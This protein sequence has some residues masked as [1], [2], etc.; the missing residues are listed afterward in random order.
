MN[1]LTNISVL[2][3]KLWLLLCL[4]WEAVRRFLVL[5]LW[6]TIHQVVLLHRPPPTVFEM[7]ASITKFL[8]ISKA[9]FALPLSAIGIGKSYFSI[10]HT[11]RPRMSGPVNNI[12]DEASE[13][14]RFSQQYLRR[15]VREIHT[16]RSH[17]EVL[18][19]GN[20]YFCSNFPHASYN[21]LKQLKTNFSNRSL[22]ERIQDRM[23]SQSGP[24]WPAFKPPLCQ[25][26]HHLPLLLWSLALSK[27][28]GI[29]PNTMHP[30]AAVRLQGIYPDDD[31]WLALVLCC[32]GSM[33]TR[34]NC[35]LAW[36]DHLW[37]LSLR[38]PGRAL[39]SCR[40]R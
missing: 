27:I 20:V 8:E 1:P 18:G 12:S 19:T 29:L 23:A 34:R 21:K 36:L 10:F 24:K 16:H 22:L 14:V 25:L 5:L 2:A 3:T 32:G 9:T 15:S 35:G 31:C 38:G 33:A 26:L 17:F 37:N 40:C 6:E 30:Q 28:A 4:G 13:K 11:K 39:C 7:K